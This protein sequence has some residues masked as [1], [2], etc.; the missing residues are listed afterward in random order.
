MRKVTALSATHGG[1]FLAEIAKTEM[2]HI[3]KYE[4]KNIN[5]A[6]I[7]CKALVIHNADSF[8]EKSSNR[9]M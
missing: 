8:I 5:L 9:Y 3:I 4:F 1:Q 7:N 6:I 2:I